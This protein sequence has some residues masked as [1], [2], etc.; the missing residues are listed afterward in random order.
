MERST[1]MKEKLRDVTPADVDNVGAFGDILFASTLKYGAQ[2]RLMTK[3]SDIK[4]ITKSYEFEGKMVETTY[5]HIPCIK[6]EFATNGGV[7]QYAHALEIPLQL[8][9]R[10]LSYKNFQHYLKDKDDREVV[11][12]FKRDNSYHYH[13]FQIHFEDEE[14]PRTND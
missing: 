13:I 2:Q 8:F 5:Y 12:V 10:A 6:C 14:E 11:I 4:V 9:N 3:F 1:T 7:N